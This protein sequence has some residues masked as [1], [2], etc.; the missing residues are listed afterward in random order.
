MSVKKMLVFLTHMIKFMQW[1]IVGIRHSRV[2]AHSAP[3]IGKTADFW[4][5]NKRKI[6][7]KLK[8]I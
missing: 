6:F 5:A 4:F 7:E 1:K 2:F 3:K 8:K